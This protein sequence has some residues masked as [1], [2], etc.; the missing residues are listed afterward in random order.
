MQYNT[1]IVKCKKCNHIRLVDGCILI[2]KLIDILREFCD[3][4]K[5]EITETIKE[6]LNDYSTFT[7]LISELFRDVTKLKKRSEVRNKISKLLD[8]YNK[9]L[10]YDK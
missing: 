9:V 5:D 8:L 6:T 7:S 1:L 2:P 10:I 4:C 3:N